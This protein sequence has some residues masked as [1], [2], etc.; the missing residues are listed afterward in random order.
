[1]AVRIQISS[2]LYMYEVNTVSTALMQMKPCTPKNIFSLTFSAISLILS[3][4][5][6][7]DFSGS[8]TVFFES[9]LQNY[10]TIY[11]PK[12]NNYLKQTLFFF[13]K[14]SVYSQI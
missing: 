13:K 8:K 11:Q 12:Q 9:F 7:A 1:M 14:E 10:L 6:W 3:E 5:Y 4:R 2:R